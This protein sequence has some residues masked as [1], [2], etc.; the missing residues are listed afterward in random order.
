MAILG[1]MLGWVFSPPIYDYLTK[2]LQN[3]LMA[4]IH[5]QYGTL[6]AKSTFRLWL[7][8]FLCLR[9]LLLLLLLFHHLVLISAVLVFLLFLWLVKLSPSIVAEVPNAPMHVVLRCVLAVVAYL[10]HVRHAVTLVAHCTPGEMADGFS[11]MLQTHK[12][13]LEKP[14]AIGILHRI[15]L[16]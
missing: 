12:A 15:I 2:W 3:D 11:L 4:D 10:L 5:S 1:R 16:I 7:L 6:S 9:L 8:G 13:C 14:A